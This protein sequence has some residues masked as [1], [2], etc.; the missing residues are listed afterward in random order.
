MT[1]DPNVLDRKN[2]VRVFESS[3][4]PL[5]TAWLQTDN[6]INFVNN[7]LVSED[8]KKLYEQAERS[9]LFWANPRVIRL[10]LVYSF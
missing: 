10:G 3:G 2:P 8:A 9:P 1:T 6:G 5:T 4:S 7:A